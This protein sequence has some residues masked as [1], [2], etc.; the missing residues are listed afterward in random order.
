PSQHLLLSGMLH[1]GQILL[2]QHDLSYRLFFTHLRMIQDLLREIVG[3]AWVD[4]ID[5]SSAEKV[6]AS[7]VSK[8]RKKRESDIIWKFRRF[9]GEAPV[10]VYVLLEHQSRPDRFMAVRLMT[11][12][13]L[14]YESLIKQQKLLPSGLLP[15][16]I[17]LVLYNGVAAWGPALEL[18]ELIER[19]HPSAER[20]V[21]RLPFHLIHEGAYPAEKLEEQESPV[22]DLF[23]LERSRDWEDVSFGISQVKQHVRPE[24]L[25]TCGR[26]SSR[27]SKR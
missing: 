6:D 1:Q 11:Y 4:L 21:P 27:G 22:A 17:P 10:Y 14:F 5:F 12:V 24:E 7:F 16:V 23:R 19:F 3:E 18:S 8:R 9:D 20:Y 26:H 2:G 13:G 25:W 15:Q